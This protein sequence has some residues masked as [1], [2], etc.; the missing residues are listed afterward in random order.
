M[1]RYCESS[2]SEL[3]KIIDKIGGFNYIK[4]CVPKEKLS[5]VV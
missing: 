2:C 4:I 3:G 5:T 1:V